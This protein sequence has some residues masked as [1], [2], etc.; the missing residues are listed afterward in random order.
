MVVAGYAGVD[1]N[2]SVRRT[3]AKNYLGGSFRTSVKDFQKL[4]FIK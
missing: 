3:R 4:I 2:S 1:T